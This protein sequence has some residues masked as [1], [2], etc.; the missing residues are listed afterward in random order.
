MTKSTALAAPL[1]GKNR[2]VMHT[3]KRQLYGE[4]LLLLEG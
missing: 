3:H 1:A 4:A 2:A